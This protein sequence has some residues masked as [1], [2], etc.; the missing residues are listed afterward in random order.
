MVLQGLFNLCHTQFQAGSLPPPGLKISLQQT[1]NTSVNLAQ[2]T[3]F[4]API[5]SQ[6][7][8]K[9]I[10]THIASVTKSGLPGGCAS[11][12]ASAKQFLESIG[13]TRRTAPLQ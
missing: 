2:N 10:R 11:T 13:L 5:K 6:C 7:N 9:Q 3:V 12:V 4:S 1:T 8:A